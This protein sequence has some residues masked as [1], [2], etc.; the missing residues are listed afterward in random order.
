MSGVDE[1]ILKRQ[2]ATVLA[3][4]GG[5]LTLD[6]KLAEMMQQENPQ[7]DFTHL[8][9]GEVKVSVQGLSRSAR[10][11]VTRGPTTKQPQ[12]ATSS[13]ATSGHSSSG[14]VTVTADEWP[15]GWEM[16]DGNGDPLP[17]VNT[18][19]KPK[20]KRPKPLPSDFDPVKARREQ[21][22]EYGRQREIEGNE[23]LDDGKLIEKEEQTVPLD[24]NQIRAFVTSTKQRDNTVS[25]KI[26]ANVVYPQE[27]SR[28]GHTLISTAAAPGKT[29][30]DF[31]HPDAG[32]AMFGK[33]DALHAKVAEEA[34]LTHMVVLEGAEIRIDLKNYN[35]TQDTHFLGRA[36]R[37]EI[38]HSEQFIKLILSEMGHEYRMYLRKEI[39]LEQSEPKQQHTVVPKGKDVE[40]EKKR[41]K[42]T[43]KKLDRAI[44]DA[45]TVHVTMGNTETRKLLDTLRGE[46]RRA[47][48]ALARILKASQKITASVE[49]KK[50]VEFSL[51]VSSQTVEQ[52]VSR[53]MEDSDYSQLRKNMEEY[54]KEVENR[55]LDDM[56]MKREQT[57]FGG[58]NGGRYA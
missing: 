38:K 26:K 40:A 33:A 46:K 32:S 45:E 13:A 2:L 36:E 27:D 20:R 22:D 4:S 16:V 24:P 19:E 12:P 35:V 25:S 41:L 31:R 1:A 30:Y 14:G 37:L 8:G 29:T 52:V 54:R 39:T 47:Q 56:K 58:V 44:K 18:L 17:Q 43:I 57:I 10:D 53:V 21:L 15:E 3:A 9:N 11:A 34:F 48:E 5:E 55:L 7:I 6:R 50:G 49:Q 51:P 23:Y 28:S 42:D